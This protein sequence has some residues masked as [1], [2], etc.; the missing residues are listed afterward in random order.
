MPPPP[1]E[2]RPADDNQLQPMQVSQMTI[3]NGQQ[4]NSGIHLQS[5][6]NDKVV[7]MFIQPITKGHLASMHNQ[8]PFQSNQLVGIPLPV[9][10]SQM[11]P[12][13]PHP[14]HG[15]GQLA[16]V[17]PETIQINQFA[18][19]GCDQGIGPQFLEQRIHALPVQDDNT[20]R[21]SSNP[22]PIFSSQRQ[23]NPFSEDKMF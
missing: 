19:H 23:N 18:G 8:Q 11:V 5:M 12:M 10:G 15:G 16:S 4:M 1:W 9:Q 3:T 13:L 7:G 14:Q 21:H 2:P 22:M 6:G 17:H 20:L